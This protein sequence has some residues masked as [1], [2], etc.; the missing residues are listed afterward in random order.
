MKNA[1]SNFQEPHLHK[2]DTVLAAGLLYQQ[3]KNTS[4]QVLLF[5]A[6]WHLLRP[7]GLAVLES[8]GL[9]HK[10]YKPNHAAHLHSLTSCRRL[11]DRVT[12]LLGERHAMENQQCAALNV[13]EGSTRVGSR[14]LSL[15][16]VQAL[17]LEEDFDAEPTPATRNMLV[18]QK[19]QAPLPHMSL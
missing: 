19:R 15:F 8:Y 9:L 7:G 11:D 6:M 4:I 2:F 14:L 18:L 13:A 10:L 17:F 3:D 1:I 12:A 5:D 16:V